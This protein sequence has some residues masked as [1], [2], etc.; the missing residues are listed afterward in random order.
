MPTNANETF[1]KTLNQYRIASDEAMINIFFFVVLP[2]YL[3]NCTVSPLIQINISF[4]S[5]IDFQL[6]GDQKKSWI[7]LFRSISPSTKPGIDWLLDDDFFVYLFKDYLA[8]EIDFIRN[9]LSS[10][11]MPTRVSLSTFSSDGHKNIC[12]WRYSA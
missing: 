6:L 11:K 5:I 4:R 7:K 2:P 10:Q 1:R 12:R 8:R 3:V 9:A